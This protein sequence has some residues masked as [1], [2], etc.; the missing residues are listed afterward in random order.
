[1]SRDR[2]TTVTIGTSALNEEA[3]IKYMLDAVF[4]QNQKN[5]KIKEIIVQSDGS[6]DK[7]AKIARGFKGRRIKMTIVA[8]R[9][10]KG[11]A[12]RINQMFHQFNSD[13][14]VMIDSD[15]TLKHENSLEEIVRP[16]RRGKNVHL[17]MGNTV[18]APA[19][20]FLESAVNNFLIVRRSLSKFYEYKK[21]A[22][23]AHAYLAYSRDFAKSFS[24]PKGIMN[25]DAYSYFRCVSEKR[26][27]VFAK[28]AEILFR[29]PQTVSDHVNQSKRH[30][31]G[32]LQLHEYF[33]AEMVYNEFYIPFKY[34]MLLLIFQILR[35][36]AGYV[37]LKSLNIYAGYKSRKTHDTFTISW[38]Q[39]ES[40]KHIF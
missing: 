19:E 17:V 3:N 30:L 10:R 4:A 34:L 9:N 24:I 35:N 14:F 12:Y 39:I 27:A 37:F 1:M 32:G 5:I 20:T 6:T 7:T 23:G 31:A 29:S 38:K 21:N 16:F 18:P 2:R 36:P 13:V 33:G 25:C 8:N 40:A 28:K 22:Y 15:M 26:K 11:V